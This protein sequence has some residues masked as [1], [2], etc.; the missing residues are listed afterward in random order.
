MHIYRIQ[1][2]DAGELPRRKH[3]TYRTRRKFE[4]KNNQT[5]VDKYCNVR[6]MSVRTCIK[7][8]RKNIIL[9]FLDVCGSVYHSIIHIGNP[10]RCNSVSRFYFIHKQSSTCFGR[11][12]ANHQEP[13]TA[14][15]ASGFA[16]LEGC[17]T[18][19]CWTLSGSA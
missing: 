1:N 9:Q 15:P 14:L 5:L 8:G 3:T 13:K 2:L 12:T 18:C 17:W 4:I 10:T 6:N 7:N 16:Y 11:H 19:S